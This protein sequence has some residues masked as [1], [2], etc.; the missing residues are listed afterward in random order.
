MTSRLTKN[1]YAELEEYDFADEEIYD[2]D[3]DDKDFDDDWDEDFE[4]HDWDE[5]FE[6][7][8]EFDS[9]PAKRFSAKHE[10]YEDD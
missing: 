10:C 3:N 2:E 5:G 9:I 1:L 7:E 6:D 4:E 8:E